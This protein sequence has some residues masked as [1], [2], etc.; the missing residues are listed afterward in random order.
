MPEGNVAGDV[1]SALQN[2][3]FKPAV[4]ASATDAAIAELGEEAG[5][6]ALHPRGVEEGERVMRICLD[7]PHWSQHVGQW[8][9]DWQTL[10][11]GSLALAAA[12]LTIRPLTANGAGRN[13]SHRRD[14]AQ[15]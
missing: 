6:S 15:A 9:Y 2:L 12:G 1:V 14:K 13:A 11:G 3:G 8:L 7:L 5:V 4:A 10:I